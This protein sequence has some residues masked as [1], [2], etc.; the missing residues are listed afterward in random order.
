MKSREEVLASIKLW[1]ININDVNAPDG[2][3]WVHKPDYYPHLQC[4]VYP[5]QKIYVGDWETYILDPATAKQPDP[6]GKGDPILGMVLA[7]LTN[8]ALEGNKKYGEPLKAHNGRNALWDA[9]QEALD[10]AMYLRQAIEE[11]RK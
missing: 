10:L 5:D 4:N 8:R 3:S 9:Y 2:W 1:P 11:Q 7:D 6:K